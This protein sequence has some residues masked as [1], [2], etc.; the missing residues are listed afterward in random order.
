MGEFWNRCRDG[1][2]RFFGWGGCG[3]PN[4]GNILLLIVAAI[5]LISLLINP[6]ALTVLALLGLFMWAIFF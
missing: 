4:N 2:K 5:L 3:G 6:I 1:C